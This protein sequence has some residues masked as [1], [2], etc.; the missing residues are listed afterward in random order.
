MIARRGSE[1]GRVWRSEVSIRWIQSPVLLLSGLSLPSWRPETNRRGPTFTVDC[2]SKTFH[3]VP[4]ALFIVAPAS[5]WWS[6]FHLISLSCLRLAS[7]NSL[8]VNVH[9]LVK[10]GFFA[11]SATEDAWLWCGQQRQRVAV[12]TLMG[13]S[14]RGGQQETSVIPSPFKWK[15]WRARPLPALRPRSHWPRTL[16]PLSSPACCSNPMVFPSFTSRHVPKDLTWLKRC[17]RITNQI[18][19]T[20]WPNICIIGKKQSASSEGHPSC[21][22]TFHPQGSG[23]RVMCSG[24]FSMSGGGW[25]LWALDTGQQDINCTPHIQLHLFICLGWKK[26]LIYLPHMTDWTLNASR[27][28]GIK[29]AK[30]IHT[31][32]KLTQH[33]TVCT[34]TKLKM[35]SFYTFIP[36]SVD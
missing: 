12:S 23:K 9:E 36:S 16:N 13:D 34:N 7:W 14:S 33:T 8:N 35:Y 3:V 10:K 24:V 20:T 25:T 29:K 2:V 6:L 31:A 17:L 15:Y 22:F 18:L 11:S 19:C 30:I 1:L 26:C 27:A 4:I 21:C 32:T 5:G 28:K